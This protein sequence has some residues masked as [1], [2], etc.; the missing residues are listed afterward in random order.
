MTTGTITT[1]RDA[2]VNI[3]CPFDDSVRHRCHSTATRGAY[4]VLMQL[5]LINLNSAVERRRHMTTQLDALGI[6]FNRFGFDGRTLSVD[7]IAEWAA[8]HFPNVDFDMDA[9]SGAEIG[10]WLSHLLAWRWLR[11]DVNGSSCTVIEDD[12]V[13]G[14]GF[15][16]A[17]GALADPAPYDLIYLGTSSRNISSRRRIEIGGRSVHEPV[18]SILNTWG[19]VISRP[20][21]EQVLGARHFRIR[22][23]IDHFLGGNVRDRRPRIGVLRPAAVWE[24]QQLGRQ[25][26]IEPHTFRPDRWRIVEDLRR[27]F[28]GSRIGELYYSVY[29]L[30]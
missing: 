17:L 30:L 26:Q 12:L 29:R 1:S 10:C 15:A 9:L 23:P 27:R 22:V 19:Y 28:L 21:V 7:A 2:D 8:R 11:E 16:A 25:S 5:A 4:A 14:A 3:R 6:A 18:G 13:L 20:Y 24:E